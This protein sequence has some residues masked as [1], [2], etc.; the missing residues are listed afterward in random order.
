MATSKNPAAALRRP[1]LLALAC[2]L[3]ACDGGEDLQ[4]TDPPAIAEVTVDAPATTIAVGDSV[5]LEAV[6]LDAAG[7]LVDD[8]AVEWTSADPAVAA[9]SSSGMVT[10]LRAG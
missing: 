3:P 1:V 6:A 9:V 7:N 8:R 10:G 5:Q 2:L 4:G